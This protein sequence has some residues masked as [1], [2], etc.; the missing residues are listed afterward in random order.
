MFRSKFT[1]ICQKLLKEFLSL[2]QIIAN[3]R[4]NASLTQITSSL[5]VDM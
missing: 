2:Q 5:L 1:K 3:V 4:K